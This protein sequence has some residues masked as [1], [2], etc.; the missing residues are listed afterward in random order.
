MRRISI[1]GLLLLTQTSCQKNQKTNVLILAV[2]S[3]SALD[4]QCSAAL[5]DK[6]NSGFAELCKNSVRFTHYYT[7]ST[8]SF[9][10][11]AS[12]MTGLPPYKSSVHDSNS[13]VPSELKT[14][15]EVAFAENFRTSFISSSPTILRKNNLQQGFTLFDDTLNINKESFHKKFF[16]ISQQFKDWLSEEDLMLPFFSV[17][18]ISDLSFTKKR[19]LLEIDQIE[20]KLIS[21]DELIEDF[22]NQLYEFINFFK[23]NKLWDKTMV[24]LVGLNGQPQTD[25]NFRH[26]VENLHSENIQ[27]ALL[28]KPSMKSRE[29]PIHWKIDYNVNTL[30][31]YLTLKHIIAKD[32]GSTTAHEALA[33]E[34]ISFEKMLDIKTGRTAL[35]YTSKLKNR[36]LVTESFF[37][38]IK[39]YAFI[40]NYNLYLKDQ[41]TQNWK[42]F[43]SLIDRAES[44]EIAISS[45]DEN[46]KKISQ[47]VIQFEKKIQNKMHGSI[48]KNSISTDII[49]STLNCDN[50]LK[51]NSKVREN[52]R[53]CT[54]PII[55]NIIRYKNA[56]ELKLDEQVQKQ[57]LLIKINQLKQLITLHN[58]KK[59]NN[60]LFSIR[61]LDPIQIEQLK[62]IYISTE[63]IFLKSELKFIL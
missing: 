35:D 5:L 60:L 32:E 63:D 8:Q 36:I 54:D 42:Y 17:L 49:T 19:Q 1:L 12:L 14:L 22:D 23:N 34:V 57:Q 51:N 62:K 27:T 20:N 61:P 56:K 3:L 13:Y 10:T 33:S 15:S 39:K 44:Q 38:N 21:S 59:S 24:V 2:E 53:N 41:K 9:P 30:D 48:I 31:L 18:Y 45:D 11:L 43:N 50:V 46:F 26:P 47:S 25:R 40:Q 55:E 29:T 16:E 6:P 7:T 4:I 52:L 37:N 58:L 28:I